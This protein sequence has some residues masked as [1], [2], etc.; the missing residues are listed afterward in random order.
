MKTSLRGLPMRKA[1]RLLLVLLW[2]CVAVFL[3]VSAEGR[4]TAQTK[5][6]SSPEKIVCPKI[7]DAKQLA[8]WATT[9]AGANTTPN[10]YTE[11][12]YYAAPVDNLRTYPVYHPD[13]E[14]KDYREWLKKQGAQPMIE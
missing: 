4:Q 12:E 10:F 13:F 5:S 7:W 2:T 9:V 11:E 6:A 8:T 1:N 3:M 14:P